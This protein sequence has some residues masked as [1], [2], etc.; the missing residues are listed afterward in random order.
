M[1]RIIAGHCLI[2]AALL[3][4][5]IT[6][7]AQSDRGTISGAV[8]DSSGAA[9]PNAEIVLTNDDTQVVTRATANDVGLYTLSNVP[10]GRYEIRITSAGFKTYHGSGMTVSRS[11]E[12]TSELQSP[13]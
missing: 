4:C 6:A 8:L 12:H 5:A 9:I 3:W 1:K 13:C 11:E 7:S 2:V 10:F